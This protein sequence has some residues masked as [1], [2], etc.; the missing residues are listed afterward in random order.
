M[1]N[2]FKKKAQP[3]QMKCPKC[4]GTMT[5]TDGLT[6]KFQCKGQDVEVPNIV[7]MLC[8]DCGEL[9]FDWPEIQRIEKYVHDAVGW[10]DAQQ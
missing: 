2:F 6:R 3:K 9:M 4:G 10:E 8:P 5:R 7:G 1:F